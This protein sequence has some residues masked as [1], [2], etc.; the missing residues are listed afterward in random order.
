MFGREDEEKAVEVVRA[1]RKRPRGLDCPE[2]KSYRVRRYT[3]AGFLKPCGIIIIVSNPLSSFS[4]P[5]WLEYVLAVSLIVFDA[6]IW[7]CP[8]CNKYLKGNFWSHGR[9]HS[10]ELPPKSRCSRPG[11]VRPE[12]GC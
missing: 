8:S 12:K 2:L 5:F 1:K 3:I 10:Q 6:M 9:V 7:R 11:Y 4:L